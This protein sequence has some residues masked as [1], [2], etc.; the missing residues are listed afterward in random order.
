MFDYAR[1]VSR[2]DSQL[3]EDA[4]ELQMF[5]IKRRDEITKNGEILLTPALSYMEKHLQI[6]IDEEKKEK[7]PN[8]QKEDEEKRK[9]TGGRDQ[10]ERGGL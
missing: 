4:V 7:L 9:A 3:Y 1:R 2:T 5:F 10:A 8:E 6:S